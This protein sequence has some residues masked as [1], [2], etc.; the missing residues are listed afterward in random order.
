MLLCVSEIFKEEFWK[1][2][3]R[4]NSLVL[5]SWNQKHFFQKQVAKE[6]PSK[7]VDILSEAA[8][9]N[10]YYTCH[11]VQVCHNTLPQCTGMLQ[12]LLFCRGFLF[13]HLGSVV[14]S[15]VS[16]GPWETRDGPRTEATR[17]WEE[18]IE[19]HQ[20]LA[21]DN[22]EDDYHDDG[23]GCNMVERDLDGNQGGAKVINGSRA[24]SEY[25]LHLL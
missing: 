13:Y 12:N 6:L 2:R 22:N 17:L 11:N 16:L 18:N 21:G 14:L 24:G 20:G 25:N 7:P 5:Y 3:G 19:N 9:R 8:M 23:D 4:L 10:A 15:R 1:R